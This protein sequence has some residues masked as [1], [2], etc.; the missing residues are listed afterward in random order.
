MAGSNP[1]GDFILSG[2]GKDPSGKGML[3]KDMLAPAALPNQ[4]VLT[5]GASASHA[6]DVVGAIVDQNGVAVAAATE[7]M[8]EGYS[9]TSGQGIIA[10]ATAPVG[11]LQKVIN[12]ATGM[13]QAWF[14]TTAGGLF[15]FKVSDSATEN[16]LV[17]VTAEGC[18]PRILKL[19]SS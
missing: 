16:C 4:I 19:A 10:A 14:T 3:S 8:V 18:I 7:V 6:T 2:T 17:R 11:T 13:S 5:P 1:V 12:P 9:I 15:S